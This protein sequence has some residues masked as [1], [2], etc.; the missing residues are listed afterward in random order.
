MT[1]P[2]L[3]HAVAE[4][5]RRASE[6]AQQ[7]EIAPETR[8]IEDLALDSLDLVAVMMN[9]QDAHDIELDLDA[10]T[11]LRTVEDLMGELGRQLRGRSAA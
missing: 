9:L 4:A 1:D 2:D 6:A 5:I 10:V 7:A 11:E 8:L 3:L